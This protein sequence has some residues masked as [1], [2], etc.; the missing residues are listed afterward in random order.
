LRA[1]KA[2]VLQW[3]HPPASRSVEDPASLPLVL[4]AFFRAF[5]FSF[6]YA[7]S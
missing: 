4:V 2:L 1:E 3:Y 7:R 5:L 6:V